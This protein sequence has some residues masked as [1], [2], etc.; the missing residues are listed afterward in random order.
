MKK[1]RYYATEKG[2]LSN[3]YRDVAKGGIVESD[4]EITAKWLKRLKD[5]ASPKPEKILPLMG[6]GSSTEPKRDIRTNVLPVEGGVFD[7][8]IKKLQEVEAKQD[9]I[10]KEQ[11]G[12]TGDKAVI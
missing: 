10:E 8:Q 11:R 1:Y 2:T 12:G 5:G 9:E 4:V 3:P 6:V 7:E